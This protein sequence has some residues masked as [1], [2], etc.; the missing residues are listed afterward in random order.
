MFRVNKTKLKQ[1]LITQKIVNL[2]QGKTQCHH[3]EENLEN[4]E[5]A[6]PEANPHSDEI[7][8]FRERNWK[9]Y[10]G[11]SLLIIFSVLLALFTTEYIN[12]Q[13]EKEN[14]KTILTS[15]VNELKH[16]KVSIQEMQE[17]NLKVLANV[18]WSQNVSSSYA[19]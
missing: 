2:F 16:N 15:I 19:L 13:H 5:Q 4:A 12:K 3:M 6:K 8:V 10:L 14:T 7:H 1:Y 9:E 18:D 17:Y 11:E